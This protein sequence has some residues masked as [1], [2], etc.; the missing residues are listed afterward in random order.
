MVEIYPCLLRV[1]VKKTRV[2]DDIITH[3]KTEYSS[4]A[5]AKV[6][7]GKTLMNGSWSQDPVLVSNEFTSIGKVKKR[8]NMITNVVLSSGLGISV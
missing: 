8:I 2:T 1:F 7:D 6:V 3:E 4:Q 5:L